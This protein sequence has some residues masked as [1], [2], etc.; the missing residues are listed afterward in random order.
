VTAVGFLGKF[1][2]T[3]SLDGRLKRTKERDRSH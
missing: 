1:G 2:D 3:I